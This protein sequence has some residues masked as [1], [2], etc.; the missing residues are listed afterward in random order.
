[1]PRISVVKPLKQIRLSPTRFVQVKEARH[2]HTNEPIE[3]IAFGSRTTFPEL[4]NF[5]GTRVK[6]TI[7][8]GN[9]R[10]SFMPTWLH[11]ETFKVPSSEHA[12]HM[13]RILCTYPHRTAE[14]EACIKAFSTHG[15]LS[16]FDVFSVWPKN[17]S[18]DTEDINKD[19]DN[20]HVGLV[21]K[22]FMGLKPNVA[23]KH[24]GF[25]NIPKRTQLPDTKTLWRLILRAKFQYKGDLCD[26]LKATGEYHLVE[27]VKFRKSA[28]RAE[29]EC[30]WGGFVSRTGE[31]DGKLLGQNFMGEQVMHVRGKMSN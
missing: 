17:L 16:N 26:F 3:Y 20:K 24:F 21:A 25:S 22:K 12:W 6:I 8:E 13:L 29:S 30:F 28:E 27:E 15:V 11:G 9:E 18:K 5:F 10:Y 14:S 23:E 19:K 4:S 2:R 31:F 7:P 1:M